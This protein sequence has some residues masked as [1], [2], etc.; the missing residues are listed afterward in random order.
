M[1]SRP[2]DDTGQARCGGPATRTNRWT[3]WRAVRRMAPGW[4][5]TTAASAST[6]RWRRPIPRT[7]G[8]R[9]PH[10]HFAALGGGYG[11]ASG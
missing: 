5:V 3:R 2:Q 1:T 4:C 8:E 9:P 11:P 10:L 6:N 7:W